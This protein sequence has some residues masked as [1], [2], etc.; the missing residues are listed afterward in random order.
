MHA[1]GLSCA[2][3]FRQYF[4]FKLNILIVTMNRMRILLT[5]VGFMA[6]TARVIAD[7]RRT[8]ISPSLCPNTTICEPINP[9]YFDTIDMV[10][11]IIFTIDYGI[12]LLTCWCVRYL[13]VRDHLAA[14]F[15][16]IDSRHKVTA[17][18]QLVCNV[19]A[20]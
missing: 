20:C 19:T 7:L 8:V 10:C 12:R 17:T 4:D 16:S 14:V 18:D 5:N 13:S 1:R 2:Y 3:I 11:V 6:R 15:Q 9:P